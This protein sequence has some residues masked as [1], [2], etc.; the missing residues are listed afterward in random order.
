MEMY[1]TLKDGWEE[2]L[3]VAEKMIIH[4]VKSLQ[5]IERYQTLTKQA[6]SLYPLAGAFKLSLNKQGGLPRITFK[7][8]RI[9][10]RSLGSTALEDDDFS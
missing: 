6:S 1:L 7:D 2:L 8:A 10:L 4:L 3:E 9:I 5:Q